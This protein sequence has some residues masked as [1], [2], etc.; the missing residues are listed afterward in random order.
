MPDHQITEADLPVV[1]AMADAIRAYLTAEE[2]DALRFLLNQDFEE[3]AMLV[4]PIA[5]AAV[6][7][8][9]CTELVAFAD[10]QPKFDLDGWNAVRHIAPHVIRGESGRLGPPPVDD[11]AGLRKFEGQVRERVAACLERAAVHKRRNAL[12]T[13]APQFGEI[14]AATLREAAGWCRDDTIWNGDD[15]A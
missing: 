3:I 13:V 11:R 14:E 2:P 4:L 8:Q 5:Q 10:A 12:D 9:V 7:E 15:D 1:N 6:R